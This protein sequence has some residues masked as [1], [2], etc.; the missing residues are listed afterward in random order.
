MV[1]EVPLVQWP[2]PRSG[3][4]KINVDESCIHGS[5]SIGGGGVFRDHNGSWLIGFSTNFGRSTPI[6]A[7]LL[8]IDQGLTPTWNNGFRNIRSWVSRDLIMDFKHVVHEVNQVA[9][10]LVKIGSHSS[11]NFLVWDSAPLRCEP[12]LDLDYCPLG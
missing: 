3:Q 10:S 11:S 8:A 1:E 7:E 9:D 2:C 6:L 4:V 12:R 5:N